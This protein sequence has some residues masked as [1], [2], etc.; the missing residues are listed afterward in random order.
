M[1]GDGEGRLVAQDIEVVMDGGAYVTL[2]P[3]VLSRGVIHAAGPYA[4]DDVRIRG[5][6]VLT[7]SPPHGAFRGF[8]APQ[9]IYANERQMDRVAQTIGMDPIELR[10]RNLIRDGQSTATG[11]VI[12]LASPRDHPPVNVPVDQR[13]AAGQEALRAGDAAD[14][15]AGSVKDKSNEQ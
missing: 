12:G 7:N 5:R 8:G 10:R 1:S 3:V 13:V 14:S 9:T 15:S 2:S 11:Q 6:V 4:C